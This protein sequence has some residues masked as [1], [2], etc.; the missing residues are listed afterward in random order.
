MYGLLFFVAGVIVGSVVA[1]ILTRVKTGRG[2]FT[3]KKIPDEEDLYT[4]NVRLV[5]DQELNKKTR[6]LLKREQTDDYSQN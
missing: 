6:I 1:Q 3:I 4:I 5:P 2:Y